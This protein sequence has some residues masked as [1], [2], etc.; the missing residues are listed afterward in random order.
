MGRFKHMMERAGFQTAREKFNFY[1]SMALPPLV[2]TSVAYFGLLQG[3]P[4]A[5]SG[6]MTAV[7]GTLAV[8]LNIPLVVYELGAGVG[9]AAA[10]LYQ[11]RESKSR[12][13]EQEV[14]PTSR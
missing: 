11:L 4:S 5:D 2:V 1:A 14:Q 10:S 8:A 13:L 3:R 9:L 12:D 7:K 6:A